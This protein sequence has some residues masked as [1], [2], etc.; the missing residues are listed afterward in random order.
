MHELSQNRWPINFVGRNQVCGLKVA[1]GAELQEPAC[2]VNIIISLA[3]LYGNYDFP[4]ILWLKASPQFLWCISTESQTKHVG[5]MIFHGICCDWKNHLNYC[6]AFPQPN[7]YTG[8]LWQQIYCTV[9]FTNGIHGRF[10]T[11]KIVKRRQEGK[12]NHSMHE[13]GVFA[14]TQYQE[15][16]ITFQ[17]W[18]PLHITLPLQAA[19]HLDLKLSKPSCATRKGSHIYGE[20]KQGQRKEW[21]NCSRVTFAAVFVLL[22]RSLVELS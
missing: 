21:Y 4:W 1:W 11:V 6:D 19:P 13:E 8:Y 17:L 10:I 15:V 18:R 20:V 5:T 22:Y 7:M 9:H 3:N 14:M 12:I 16:E 2:R